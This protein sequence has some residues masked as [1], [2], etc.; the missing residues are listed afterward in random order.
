[1]GN[2]RGSNSLDD[3]IPPLE[4]TSGTVIDLSPNMEA[5]QYTAW[6]GPTTTPTTVNS[7][8]IGATA[9]T[10]AN[11]GATGFANAAGVQ[12]FPSSPIPLPQGDKTVIALWFYVGFAPSSTS[13][14]LWVELVDGSFNSMR[15][16]TD[17][18][19]GLRCGWNCVKMPELDRRESTDSSYDYP[20]YRG[21]SNTAQQS[22]WYEPG[23][24]FDPTTITLMRVGL[25]NSGSNTKDFQYCGMTLDYKQKPTVMFGFDDGR[26]T[27]DTMACV[28]S[29]VA[30]LSGPYGGD[31]L[32]GADVTTVERLRQLEMPYCIP[33]IRNPSG[34]Q[35]SDARLKQITDENP[36]AEATTH[37]GDTMTV[38]NFSTPQA[39][40]EG[41][42]PD[43]PVD[44][45]EGDG[46]RYNQKIIYDLG[47]NAKAHPDKYGDPARGYVY[48]QN[49]YRNSGDP[50]PAVWQED[51]QNAAEPYFDY[52]ATSAPGFYY[53]D[54]LANMGDA[55]GGFGAVP[56]MNPENMQAIPTFTDLINNV[57]K[58][59]VQSQGTAVWINTH[60]MV[61][62]TIAPY[63]TAGNCTQPP[64][65]EAGG[66]VQ[67]YYVNDMA[68]LI[69]FI[70][71]EWQAG[72]LDVMSPTTYVARLKASGFKGALYP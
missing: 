27:V 69:N 29:E 58:G 9:I 36:L 55:T 15:C 5:S 17:F 39:C 31:P 3:S 21:A 54:K 66:S 1:M 44:S 38:T 63:T 68:V 25:A 53:L 34:Q 18:S 30:T 70:Y 32:A 11:T 6:N 8:T 43:G 22:C 19:N 40:V 4:F 61:D 35:I 12:Y 42:Y 47:M 23:V 49:N 51:M 62:S 33:H 71:N 60:R 20:G 26:A 28:G 67:D 16:K 7:N 52:Q 24:A 2:T 56:R 59:A 57:I 13:I 46:Q 10:W 14:E 72:R 37:G 64:E 65:V 48:P 50:D 41:S 45:P